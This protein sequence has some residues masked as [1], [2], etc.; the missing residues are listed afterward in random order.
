M[1]KVELLVL[2][3]QYKKVKSCKSTLNAFLSESTSMV[4]YS[5]IYSESA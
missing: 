3:C 2:T 1:N 4:F 5:K